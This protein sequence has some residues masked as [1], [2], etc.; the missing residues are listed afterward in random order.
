MPPKPN[1]LSFSAPPRS[2]L[3][4]RNPGQP[5]NRPS[6][7]SRGDELRHSIEVAP[8]SRASA[9]RWRSCGHDLPKRIGLAAPG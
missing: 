4:R 7:S 3:S 6:A 9:T 8:P 1:P 5:A 2:N